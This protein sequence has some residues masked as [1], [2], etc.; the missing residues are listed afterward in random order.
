[1]A[2]ILLAS[3]SPEVD[4]AARNHCAAVSKAQV[5]RL[6]AM[7]DGIE[8]DAQYTETHNNEFSPEMIQRYVVWY[9]KRQSEGAKYPALHLTKLSA[10][11][12]IARQKSIDDF[13]DHEKAERDNILTDF[14]NTLLQACPW[15]AAEIK[16]RSW[17]EGL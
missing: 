16:A 13:L 8:A 4:Q 6:R 1:M 2:F 12:R 7:A 11:E 17:P 9:R 3:T 14:R 5:A 15:R 10:S